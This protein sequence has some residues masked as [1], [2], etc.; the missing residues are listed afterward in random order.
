MHDHDSKRKADKS[1]H[2][3]TGWP[4]I[5]Y[6]SKTS[7]IENSRITLLTGLDRKT[8]ETLANEFLILTDGTGK[9]NKAKFQALILYTM[10]GPRITS[11]GILASTIFSTYDSNQTGILEFTE[12][13]L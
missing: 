12:F 13:V 11:V 10:F 3:T 2:L 7:P 8:V 6:P 4:G 5:T 1:L 9:I